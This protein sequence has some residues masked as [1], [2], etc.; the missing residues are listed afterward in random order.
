MTNCTLRLSR[1][2]GGAI[3][4][5]DRETNDIRYDP[6]RLETGEDVLFSGDIKATLAIGGFDTGGRVYIEHSQPYPFTLSAIIRS[7]T[8]GG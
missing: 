2:Y 8:M 3:G 5:S 1:S 7:V 4:A 6:D